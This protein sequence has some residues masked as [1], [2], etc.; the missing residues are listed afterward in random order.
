MFDPT[1]DHIGGASRWL[2]APH[3]CQQL[4]PRQWLTS[5]EGEQAEHGTLAGRAKVN[6]G[7][8]KPCPDWA[9]D[10]DAHATPSSGFHQ[11][12]IVVYL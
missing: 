11:T 4:G 5:G 6:T 9:E 7:V 12:I 3:R 8:S 1:L 10:L 2:F